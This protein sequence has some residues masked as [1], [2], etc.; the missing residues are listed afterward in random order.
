MSLGVRRQYRKM[1]KDEASM[2]LVPKWCVF[3]FGCF[4]TYKKRGAPAA[5]YN[6]F[7]LLKESSILSKDSWSFFRYGTSFHRVLAA[8]YSSLRL[9]ASIRRFFC[10]LVPHSFDDSAAPVA[11]FLCFDS[12]FGSAFNLRRSFTPSTLHFVAN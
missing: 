4:V 3:L 2:L 12:T 8:I 9:N 1:F 11:F 5:S 7:L 6:A 10:S